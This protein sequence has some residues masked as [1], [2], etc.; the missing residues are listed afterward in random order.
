[1][2]DDKV[3]DL[4][5]KPVVVSGNTAPKLYAALDWARLQFDGEKHIGVGVVVA[6]YMGR[7]ATHFFWEAGGAHPVMSGT[8]LLLS[9]E[10]QN[11]ETAMD[12]PTAPRGADI[13]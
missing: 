10:Q 13:S 6:D 1:M 2:S 11:F 5:G 8:A 3:V 4:Q 7:V 9:R 12:D